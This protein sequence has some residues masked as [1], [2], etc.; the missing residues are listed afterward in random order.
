MLKALVGADS[1]GMVPECVF[2]SRQVAR[3]AL[4]ALLNMQGREPGLMTMLRVEG[5]P[6]IS[7]GAR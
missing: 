7:G 4:P 3:S 1:G 6:L 2:L 5:L